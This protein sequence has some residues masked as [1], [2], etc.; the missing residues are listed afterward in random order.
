MF[1]DFECMED[2]GCHVPNP[3]VVQNEIGEE[4]VFSGPITK[5]DFCQ[6][7]FLP[8]NANTTFVAHNFQAYDGYFI[9][10]YLYKQGLAPELITR[11]ATILFLTVKK[12][13]IKFIDSL[14]FTPMKLAAFPKTFGLEEPVKGWSPPL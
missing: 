12:L 13:N 3:C 1:F 10:Q 8:T 2:T 7:L 9:V 11:G 5:D 6:W 4:T 14:C